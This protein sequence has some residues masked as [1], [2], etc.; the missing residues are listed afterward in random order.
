[1]TYKGHLALG[2]A[3]GLL[4][5]IY[6][7]NIYLN[8]SDYAYLF[9]IIYIYS[10][11]PDID[12]P[13]SHLSK[14]FP[15]FII[16]PLISLFTRHRGF[17]HTIWAAFIASLIIFLL[18]YYVGMMSFEKAFLFTQVAFLSY[19]SHIIG[20]G[21]TKG[22][23]RPFYPLIDIK[24]YFLPPFLRFQT[25]SWMEFIYFLLFL[26]IDYLEINYLFNIQTGFFI[27]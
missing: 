8:S 20:D 12:E 4:P 23:V 27:N 24:L 15:F 18:S 25:G 9:G 26:G 10:Q 7:E 2:S 17:T 5:L 1:M 19:I 21:F 16:S 13:E 11:L 14:K 22:G 6:N 3:F